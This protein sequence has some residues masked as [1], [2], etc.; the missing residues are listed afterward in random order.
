[1]N[2]Y[3][4]NRLSEPAI[5]Y[6][7]TLNTNNYTGKETVPAIHYRLIRVAEIRS[8]RKTDAEPTNLSVDSV[9]W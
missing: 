1:M 6:L 7:K 3:K 9:V 5:F 2:I 8:F 4:S